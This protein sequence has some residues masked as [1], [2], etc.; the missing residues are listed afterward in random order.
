GL[1]SDKYLE[2]IPPDS[3]AAKE[4]G[5]LSRDDI[6]KKKLTKIECLNKIAQARN[7][8]LAQMALAW[9]LRKPG[10]TSALMGASRV[11][12]VDDA[13]RALENL[14]FTAKELKSIDSTCRSFTE[15][16]T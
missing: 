9:V 10:V 4:H 15:K 6:T 3:R 1:L 16:L 5:Y 7:Q 13:V 12:H 8:S 14:E 11:R 2:G